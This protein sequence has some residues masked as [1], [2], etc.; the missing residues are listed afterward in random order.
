M[1]ADLS[2]AIE[3]IWLKS[4]D[5]IARRIATLEAAF[6]ALHAG[7]LA[8]E[9]LRARC[10]RCAELAASSPSAPP[11]ARS[12]GDAATRAAPPAKCAS[13][14]EPADRK[15]RQGGQALGLLDRHR[16]QGRTP[17]RATFAR[18]AQGREARPPTR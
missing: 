3:A 10:Q 14:R 15:D 8:D 12:D 13:S 9:L 1:T 11:A 5:E 7:A 4:R 18:H 2:P 6:A 17:D 16:A